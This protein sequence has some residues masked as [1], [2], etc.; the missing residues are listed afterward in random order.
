MR[1]VQEKKIDLD[2]DVNSYLKRWKIPANKWLSQRAVTTRM[3]LNHTA[4]FGTSIGQVY[5]PST[6]PTL[7]QQLNG[8]APA[9]NP[10][11]E[12]QM[13]PGSKFEYSNNG[14]MVLQLLIEDV[15]GKPFALAMRQ[16]VLDPLEMTQSTF[17]MPLPKERA[18]N[19][20][21]AFGTKQRIGMPADEYVIPNLAAG[22]LWST[23][24]DLAKVAIEIQQA[25][26]GKHAKILAQKSARMMLTPGEGFPVQAQGTIYRGNE[27]WGLGLE[28][29]GEPSHP[30]FDHSGGGVYNSIMFMYLNGDGM[31]VMANY[32]LS[33]E[34][35]HEL[36]YSAG[37][38]Y[39][40]PDFAIEEH[41]RYP[42][43][44]DETNALAGD[45]E[46]GIHIRPFENG[47]LYQSDDD[48]RSAPLIPWSATRLI[49]SGYASELDFELDP[50]T[51]RAV[52]IHIRNRQYSFAVKRVKPDAPPVH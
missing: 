28:M 8:Q 52:S 26:A 3:L 20:A 49:L 27:H 2:H 1:L 42:L 6:A 37:N 7:L 41:T 30:F 35:I 18:E 48:H 39:H 31:V 25:Y 38:V 12:L 11:V 46:G 34:L 45:Y 14:Y 13:L 47:L 32:V 24:T 44:V 50:T 17:E 10:P 21:S 23:P 22:G 9:T 40:W 36:L 4:G 43:N 19:A 5:K 51:H 15:T 16:L 33:F 29:A